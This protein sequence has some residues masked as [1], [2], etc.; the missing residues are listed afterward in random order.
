ME[1]FPKIPFNWFENVLNH[2]LI[3]LKSYLPNNYQS[4]L[5]ADKSKVW[6]ATRLCSRANT[7]PLYTVC[8]ATFGLAVWYTNDWCWFLVD[9]AF[10]CSWGKPKTVRNK[11]V[12]IARYVTCQNFL[13]RYIQVEVTYFV[14]LDNFQ[15][16]Q[17]FFQFVPCLLVVVSWWTLCHSLSL[18]VPT[19]HPVY[20]EKSQHRHTNMALDHQTVG[21]RFSLY[22][23]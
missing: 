11:V 1:D 7:F 5:Y 19:G 2:I 21:S 18:A 17:L 22:F 16:L 20:P 13:C 14:T 8:C 9:W 4:H 15:F 6:C 10:I 23:I 12:K 3:E